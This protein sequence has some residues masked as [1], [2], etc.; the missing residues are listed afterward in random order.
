MAQNPKGPSPR[1]PRRKMPMPQI[2]K[3]G[4]SFWFNLATSVV[5]LVLLAGL[6]SYFVGGGSSAPELI[7]ISQVAADINAG[8]V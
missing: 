5:V 7:P 6:Y 8:M 3:G 2:P 1:K 4:D